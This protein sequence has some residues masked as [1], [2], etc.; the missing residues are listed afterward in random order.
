MIIDT[1]QVKDLVKLGLLTLMVRTFYYL[2]GTYFYLDLV[3]GIVFNQFRS[4]FWLVSVRSLGSVLYY[5]VISG[6]L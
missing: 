3:G 5:E 1:L 6:D 2:I 4:V